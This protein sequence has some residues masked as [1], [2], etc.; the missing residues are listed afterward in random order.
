M[1]RMGLAETASAGWH[2]GQG[3][4]HRFRLTEPLR[5]QSYRVFNPSAAGHA[6]IR[7]GVIDTDSLLEVADPQAFLR[8]L[9]K[10]AAMT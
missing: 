2:T 4:R 3:E 9:A 6:L 8:Q 10:V 1:Q 5:L 7:F